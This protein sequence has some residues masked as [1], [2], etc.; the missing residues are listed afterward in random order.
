MQAVGVAGKA[1]SQGVGIYMP[2]DDS[3][4]SDVT[5]DSMACNGAPVTYFT[6]SSEVIPVK[7][8][9]I[10]TG[11]WLHTLTSTGADDSADNKVID[12]SHKGPVMAYMKKVA[13]ATQ[14][15][16]A[17]PG[18]GWFK[19]SEAG[20]ISSTEWGVDA[21][22][23]AGGVQNVTIPDC[24]EDGQYLL[25]FEVIALHSASVEKD[26][27][28]YMECAQIS[29]SGGSGAGTPETHAIP[30][31]YS[32]TDP[33]IKVNIY[34]NQGQPYPLSGT[35]AIPGPEVFTCGAST[36]NNAQA[37]SSKVAS[38][39][40]PGS[41]ATSTIPATPVAPV[42]ASTSNAPSLSDSSPSVSMAFPSITSN[43]TRPY[44]SSGTATGESTFPSITSNTTR[45]YG[46]LGAV[47]G[48]STFVTMH[49][50][51]HTHHYWEPKTCE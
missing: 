35:Y 21:L 42:V 27:Q 1:Y 44:G 23:S 41:S 5:S 49:R 39:I 24:I 13:D 7:A 12:S 51:S 3:F 14:N 40:T 8:G 28:F 46:S 37:T 33:G 22:I 30:G 31:I 32:A 36:A 25:R 4:Q 26:A 48:A 29:V 18:D 10:V 15:P 43:T 11:S 2:G 45:P 6:S 16:S 20:L 17:G 50:P 9:D 34:N 47:T 19:I 38:S